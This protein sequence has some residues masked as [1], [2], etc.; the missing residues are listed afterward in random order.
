MLKA[1][2]GLS[3]AM[4]LPVMQSSFFEDATG[5]HFCNWYDPAH[6]LEGTCASRQPQRFGAFL[7]RLGPFCPRETLTGL[8]ARWD[9][10]DM[11]A[12]RIDDR[13][14]FDLRDILGMT[15]P[16][17]MGK[18]GPLCP[19]TSDLDLLGNG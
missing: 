11:E 19:D 4:F 16:E 9:Y 18:A 13:R 1:E 2:T 14:S 6:V 12:M 7:I 8:E 5:D 17:W 15:R 10:Q 3:R